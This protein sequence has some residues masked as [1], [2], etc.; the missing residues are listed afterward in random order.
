MSDDYSD[1]P[2]ITFVCV[3]CGAPAVYVE[4]VTEEATSRGF[5]DGDCSCEDHR[6]SSAIRLA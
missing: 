5:V 3:A 4:P 2:R 6:T 1:D